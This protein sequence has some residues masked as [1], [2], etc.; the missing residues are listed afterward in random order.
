MCTM[1]LRADRIQE[2]GEAKLPDCLKDLRAD[3][4]YHDVSV[5]DGKLVARAE[6]IKQEG[7][8]EIL[9]SAWAASLVDNRPA[10][11]FGIKGAIAKAVACCGYRCPKDLVCSIFLE[12]SVSTFSRL[13]LR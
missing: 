7:F 4:L 6:Q 2:R 10:K 11:G 13:C 3:K 9:L 1:T 12:T 5:Q 8:S